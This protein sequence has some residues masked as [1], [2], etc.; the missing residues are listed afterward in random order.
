LASFIAVFIIEKYGRRNLM[1]YTAAA[2]SSAYLPPFSSHSPAE[3]PPFE[4]CMALLTVTTHPNV[5]R[6][7]LAD[8]N[9]PLSVEAT[10]TAPGYVAAVWVESRDVRTPSVLR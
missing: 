9:D 2:M 8:P 5:T 10:N 3:S 6:P 7:R 4:V 1:L